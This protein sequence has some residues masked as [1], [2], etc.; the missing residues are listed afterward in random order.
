MIPPS[1]RGRSSVARTSRCQREG[2]GFE[3]HRPLHHTF[4]STLSFA[5]AKQGNGIRIT[6]FQF[7]SVYVKHSPGSDGKKSEVSLNILFERR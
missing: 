4:P 3:S 6:P 7:F 1:T 2:R 5:Q